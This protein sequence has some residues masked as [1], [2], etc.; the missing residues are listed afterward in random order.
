MHVESLPATLAC[1]S[2]GDLHRIAWVPADY[3]ATARGEIRQTR[4]IRCGCGRLLE[5]TMDFH[6]TDEQIAAL[7]DAYNGRPSDE[8]DDGH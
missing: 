8:A 2:C 4:R 3:R 5:F 6:A 7:A 1:P